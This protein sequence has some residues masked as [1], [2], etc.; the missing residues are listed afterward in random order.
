MA[1]SRFFD[2]RLTYLSF[3]TTSNEKNIVADQLSTVIKSISKEKAALRIF[4]AGI[5]DGSLLMNVIKNCHKEFP[6]IPF[7]VMAKEI[8]I[9]D[10]RLALEKL[11]DR[12]IEHPNMVFTITNLFFSE[13]PALRSKNSTKQKKM[14]WKTLAL[15]G[16]SSYEFN[17]QL[18]NIDELLKDAW[19]ID[20]D[21]KTNRATYRNPS[22]LTI[23]RKD[24]ENLVDRYIPDQNDDKKLFDLI[25]AS[26]PYRSRTSEKKKVDFVIKP[27]IDALN[28][29]GK[30]AV[31]HSAGGDSVTKAIKKIWPSEVPFPTPASKIIKYLKKSLP[32]KKLDDLVFHKP[33]KFK[34]HLK[35]IPADNNSIATSLFSAAWNNI[36]YVGQMSADKIQE[37]QANGDHEEVI[38]NLLDDENN[39]I[40]FKNE[41][42]VIE[43]NRIFKP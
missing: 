42:F 8:S 5:G 15:D 12:F 34:F 18:T 28:K 27:M 33:V 6:Y 20:E 2:D 1:E 4:D 23:Y 37:A 11:S 25:I 38:K 7:F 14:K 39:K 32:S 40:H 3:V 17:K 13:A 26:Q 35:S 19:T 10:V 41:I 29:N 9:E 22:V 21:P 30:L 24:H 31:I 43:K 16:N 36:V